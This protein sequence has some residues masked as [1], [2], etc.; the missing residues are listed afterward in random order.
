MGR[1]WAQHPQRHLRSHRQ[2][3]E[4]PVARVLLLCVA[5]PGSIGLLLAYYI[6]ASCLLLLVLA[7]LL[8]LLLLQI[9]PDQWVLL[10]GEFGRVRS[11]PRAAARGI[12]GAAAA[13]A[14]AADAAGDSV[15]ATRERAADRRV[16][17]VP[18]AHGLALTLKP[19]R[20]TA[21][22]GAAADGCG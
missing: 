19:R 17:G 10:M 12:N 20:G 1:F 18:A 22:R 5:V 9:K 14:D 21:T 11:L 13:D 2:A 6:F 16:A 4:W 3:K 15:T 8:Q 7:L